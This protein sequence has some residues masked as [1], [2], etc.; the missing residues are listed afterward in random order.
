M[1]QPP[2]QF[3]ETLPR[4]SRTRAPLRKADGTAPRSW[5]CWEPRLVLDWKMRLADLWLLFTPRKPKWFIS[6]INLSSLLPSDVTTCCPFSAWK[7]NA[8]LPWQ[9]WLR[10]LYVLWRLNHAPGRLMRFSTASC[11]QGQGGER[12]TDE[13]LIVGTAPGTYWEGS[14]E[15]CPLRS[16]PARPHCE[17]GGIDKTKQLPRTRW[18]WGIQRWTGSSETSSSQMQF[19]ISQKGTA[20]Q[21][22]LGEIHDGNAWLAWRKPILFPNKPSMPLPHA[23]SLVCAV[24]HCFHASAAIVRV[25]GPLVAVI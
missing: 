23:P 8:Q 12:F 21:A 7:H 14:R 13:A 22:A 18:K 6:N 24:K 10:E 15:R 9:R 17:G 2:Q 1:I 5:R 20:G 19:P 11:M 3:S 4:S 16:S 25:A